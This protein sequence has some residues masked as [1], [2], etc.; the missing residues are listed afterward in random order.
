ML[1]GVSRIAT[2]SKNLTPFLILTV[3]FLVCPA[4]AQSG[5]SP[6]AALRDFVSALQKND[7]QAAEQ[8]LTD[9][10][11]TQLGILIEASDRLQKTRTGFQEAMTS[12]F[13]TLSVPPENPVRDYLRSIEKIE[14]KKLTESGEAE[15]RADVAISLKKRQEAIAA[16]ITFSNQNGQWKMTLPRTDQAAQNQQLADRLNGLAQLIE[17]AQRDVSNGKFQNSMEAQIALRAAI[18]QHSAKGK[19]R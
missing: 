9:Q 11:R 10:S 12:K 7:M 18:K 1:I 4:M 2:K 17:Q 16:T 5:A 14:I 19:P 13:G 3:F 6:E 15:R 8:L